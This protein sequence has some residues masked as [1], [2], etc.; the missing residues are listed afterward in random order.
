MLAETR[1]GR[2]AASG[3]AFIDPDAV[4]PLAR[5]GAGE[6]WDGRFAS[7][8]A[9]AASRGW[10]NASDGWVQAHVVWDGTG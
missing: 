5:G 9:F 8:L 7:M 4:R 10:T 6:G 1:T 2:L 3:D